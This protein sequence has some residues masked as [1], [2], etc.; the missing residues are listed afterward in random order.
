[1]D[2]FVL[3]DV[4]LVHPTFLSLKDVFDVT[5]NDLGYARL[6]SILPSPEYGFYM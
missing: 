1:M 6:W 2:T 3:V 5:A 4:D